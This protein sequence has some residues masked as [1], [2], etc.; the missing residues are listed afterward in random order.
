MRAALEQAQREPL[1]RL[2]PLCGI[3]PW[4]AHHVTLAALVAQGLL[5]HAEHLTRR[6]LRLE[7]WTITDAGRQALEPIVIDRPDR[8][9]YLAP[10]G[11]ALRY[12]KVPDLDARRAGKADAYK[13]E[14]AGGGGDYTGDARRS[15]DRDLAPGQTTTVAIA[16]LD[17]EG[18]AIK[19]AEREQ[20]RRRG[21]ADEL[22]AM[23]ID[24]RVQRLRSVARQH[25]MN[26]NSDVHIITYW[27][28]RGRLTAAATRL[29]A[30]ETQLGQRA[31]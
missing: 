17:A 29:T 24:D 10:A 26:V 21:R 18:A 12:R 15:I 25:R 28:S 22:D 3:A 30:L 4:P 11:G 14:I 7:E 23:P 27:I 20:E 31:A 8:P 16:V 1:R 2:H 9:R 6:G 13:W 19:A 5:E